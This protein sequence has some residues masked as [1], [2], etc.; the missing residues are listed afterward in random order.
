[1]HPETV[2]LPLIVKSPVIVPPDVDNLVL[3]AEK[4]PLAYEAAVLATPYAELAY[5]PLVTAFWS[6]VFAAKK[7]PFAYEAAELAVPNAIKLI[8]AFAAAKAA[9]A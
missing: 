3:A 9:L 6:A 5:E 2:M 4:A 1:M 8:E 7:A